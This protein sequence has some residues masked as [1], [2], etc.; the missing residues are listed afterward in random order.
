MAL[1]DAQSRGRGRH[2][3]P[4][5][6]PAGL[7]IYCSVLLKPRLEPAHLGA[8]PLAAG[9]AAAQAVR[10]VARLG[11]SLKWP[12][13]L[14]IGRRKLGGILVEAASRGKRQEFVIVGW[15]L[16]LRQSRSDFPA[17]LA[18][19]VISVRQARGR[20]GERHSF[21]ASFISALERLLGRLE[22]GD[23]RGVL[24]RFTALCPSC[25]GAS[26]QLDLGGRRR[27]A[28]SRGLAADGSLRVDLAE[29]RRC[30][31]GSERLRILR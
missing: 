30:L 5:A 22:A 9:I 14:L 31:Q 25:R 7:G 26:L 12:N 18:G 10:R 16:N 13:D 21:L 4:W 3:R 24:T 28:V 15:G 29:G 17:S 1:A 19:Q 20:L 27:H 6:S 11:A 8:L 2:G 23:I